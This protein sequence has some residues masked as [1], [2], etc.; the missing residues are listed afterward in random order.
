VNAL[1][2]LLAKVEAGERLA[3]YVADRHGDYVEEL[4]AYRKAGA[5]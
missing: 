3:R 1:P 4:D 2:Y 5:E